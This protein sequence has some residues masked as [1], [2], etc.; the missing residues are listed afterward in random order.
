M[1]DPDKEEKH[2]VLNELVTMAEAAV[3]ACVAVQGQEASISGATRN[4]Y[5]ELLSR[6]VTLY[7]LSEDRQ[8]IR[9]LA[10]SDMD[11]GSFRDGGR[12][13]F[14][15]DGRETIREL[16]VARAGLKAAIEVL[17]RAGGR[18]AKEA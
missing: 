6:L 2:R 1:N 4:L 13:M 3:T 5:A 14:F 11:G 10:R 9:A 17:K 18:A 12:E 16:A 8:E 15:V 7:A